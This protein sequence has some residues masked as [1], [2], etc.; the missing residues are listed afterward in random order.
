[1]LREA[2]L[3]SSPLG[4]YVFA[5]GAVGEFLPIVAM[6]LLLTSAGPIAGVFALVGMATATFIALWIIRFVKARQWGEKFMLAEE[7]TGQN[8]LRWTLVLLAGLVLVA[9]D[10]GLDV[11]LGAFLAGVVL[12]QWAPVSA[13]SLERKL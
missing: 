4:P 10:F 13:E 12:R 11:V 9:D 8:T 5:A 1:I 7:S 3:M 2:G 6:A